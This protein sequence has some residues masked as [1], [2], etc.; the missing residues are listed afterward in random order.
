MTWKETKCSSVHM[1]HSFQENLVAQY[2]A[3]RDPLRN[4]FFSIYSRLGVW[5]ATGVLCTRTPFGRRPTLQVYIPTWIT[6]FS[7][8]R[9]PIK[10]AFALGWFALTLLQPVARV[11]IYYIS[12]LSLF[13]L[14]II[15]LLLGTCCSTWNII[16]GVIIC[17]VLVYNG[18]KL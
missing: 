18:D 2:F 14:I 10:I 17:I 11:L 16:S 3:F 12:S 7:R 1:I 6:A 4:V 5:G 9:S 13:S 15:L 8:F